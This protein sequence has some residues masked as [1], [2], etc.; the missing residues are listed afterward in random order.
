MIILA[1][2]LMQKRYKAK[3]VNAIGKYQAPQM[4]FSWTKMKPNFSSF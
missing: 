3:V 4:F 1:A 2:E